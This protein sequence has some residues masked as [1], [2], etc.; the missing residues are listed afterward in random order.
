MKIN[1][2]IFKTLKKIFP[3]GLYT[4]SLIIIIA[5]I[6]ILQAILTFVFLE[7]H[8]QLV[9]KK[10]SSSVVSEIGMMID[11][12]KNNDLIEISSNAK[13][14]YDI[15]LRLLTNQ[16]I[17]NDFRLPANL[18]EK[19]L[20]QEL[21]KNL[22]N[23]YSIEDIPE[24]KK[25]IINIEVE[26]GILEFVIPRRNVYATNSH[27]FLVWM[28]I[29]SILILSIAILFLRQQIKPIEKLAK[30]AESFGIGRKIK[31]FKPTGAT[32]VRKAADAY[33]KMQE[34]IEK[35]LEQRTLMLAG[36]SHDLRTPLTRIKL[37]L[38][39]YSNQKGNTELLKD[40]N[41]MQYML[42][43]YL[44]FSQT[45]SSEEDTEVD[46][47]ELIDNI[48]STSNEKSKII[49]LKPTNLK[50]I[51]YICKKIALKRCVIN[52][53]NNAKAF[54]DE[55]LITLNESNKEITIT[56]EDNGPGIP[57]KDYEKALRPFQRLDS[58]RNQNIAGSG[59]GLSISQE[60]MNSIGGNIKLSKSKLGGLKVMIALPLKGN[61]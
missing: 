29:S 33:I 36:V 35:F 55:V 24:E 2:P 30:A 38:E 21:Q 15:N 22:D 41:E 26:N 32:E 58:S 9:T 5:P 19:T 16:R 31:N 1:L 13:K 59:L 6:V 27:I 23:K 25:V 44:D 61:I 54:G 39:M 40:V 60:I 45:V 51:K 48:I 42:E 17:D 11:M 10:L 56:I 47:K 43:T 3:S 8:W 49:S 12:Q 37:Q 18:V 28:V 7:R 46:L 14:F 20:S 34:R 52:L 57:K 50:N 53:I 4:R